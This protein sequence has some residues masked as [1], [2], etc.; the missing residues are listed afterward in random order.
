MQESKTISVP[1]NTLRVYIDFDRTLFDTQRFGRDLNH[2]VAMHAGI[3]PEQARA[4]AAPFYTHAI[5]HSF[6]FESY[7]TAYGLNPD[8]MLDQ[9]HQLALTNPYLYDDSAW[10]M[11]TLQ[12]N[13]FNPTILSFGEDRFQRAKITPTLTHL[14]ETVPLSA[15]KPRTN[16]RVILEPKGQ[17]IALKHPGEQGVLVD[18]IPEQHL[19]E[20]FHEI[21]LDREINLQHPKPKTGGFTVS[22]LRQAYASI[23]SLTTR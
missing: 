17:H 20:G 14:F 21:H 10:F 7:V 11:Q 6:D 1:P 8:A 15:P 13:G 2:I 22:D 4:D 16:V 12:N 19:P 23:A 18:D 9:V 3:S 5:L